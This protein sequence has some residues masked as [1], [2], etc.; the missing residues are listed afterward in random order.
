MPDKDLALGD[1]RVLDLSEGVPGSYCAK[2]MAGLGAHVIKVER[3]G[4]GD[5]SR[6]TGPFPNDEPHPEKSAAFLYLNTGKKSITLNLENPTGAAILKRLVQDSD[7]LIESFPVG[8]M[9]G[10]GLGYSDLESL[11]PTLVYTAISPFGQTGPYRDY[12]NSDIV[13][14]AMGALMD[15]IGTPDR[16]PLKIG[17]NAALYTVGMGAF[18]GTMLAIYAR[19][20]QG[21]GEFVDVSAME[22]ITVAQIHSSIGYQFRGTNQTRRESALLLAGDGY[23]NPGLSV[24]V[25]EDTWRNVCDLIGHPELADDPIFS[26]REGRREYQEDLLAI[27][28]AWVAEQPSK[29]EIYHQVQALRTIAGYV[30]TVEDLVKSK[31]FV[32]REYFISMDHPVAGEVIYPGAPFTLAGEEWQHSRAPLLGEHN[33]EVYCDSLGY[34]REDFVKL[35]NLGVI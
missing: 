26:T 8:Y 35:S 34:S 30:A 6:T 1:I 16:G 32:A 11:N 22:T 19:D 21:H 27:I 9:D 24:G 15:T 14:Q 2:V 25:Q 10:I 28:G 33:A 7:V 4:S 13:T 17:G 31:Q 23:V 29:E 20:T 5:V 12:K 3:P 18:S